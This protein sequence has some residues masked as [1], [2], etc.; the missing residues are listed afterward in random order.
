MDERTL[1][2][3]WLKAGVLLLLLLGED[4]NRFYYQYSLERDQELSEIPGATSI[5]TNNLGKWL[6]CC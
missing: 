1:H 5:S 6:L 4:I 2:S 3:C